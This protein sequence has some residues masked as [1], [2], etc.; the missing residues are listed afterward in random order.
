MTVAN[1]WLI[2]GVLFP[3]EG[4]HEVIAQ[5]NVCNGKRECGSRQAC[6]L[7]SFNIQFLKIP[8]TQ[9]MEIERELAM[10]T[11]TRVYSNACTSLS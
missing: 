7:V 1:L 6:E 9:E 5:D 11:D 2:S 3:E 10:S 4:V 8:A